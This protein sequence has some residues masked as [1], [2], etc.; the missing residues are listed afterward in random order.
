MGR[1]LEI[2]D[3]IGDLVWLETDS[4]HLFKLALSLE[5]DWNF[6]RMVAIE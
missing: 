4:L 3:K 5:K 6:S 2:E 1:I